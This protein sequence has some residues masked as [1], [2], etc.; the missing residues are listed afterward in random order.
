MEDAVIHL[1]T[2]FF[3]LLK[4]CH[5]VHKITCQTLLHHMTQKVEGG[6]LLISLDTKFLDI[7]ILP[8]LKI[9]SFSFMEA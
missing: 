3:L 9:V 5:L 6:Q 8:Y 7:F 4:V 1:Q 2:L